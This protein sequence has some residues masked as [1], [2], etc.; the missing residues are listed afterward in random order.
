MD[1]LSKHPEME[2][3]VVSDFGDLAQQPDLERAL[4][5]Y[6]VLRRT[7]RYAVYSLRR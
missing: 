2:Y 5:E 3:F 4:S 7:P 6:P 1:M